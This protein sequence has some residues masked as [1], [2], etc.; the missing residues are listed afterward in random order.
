MVAAVTPISVC[1][2]ARS[3]HRRVVCAQ[4]GNRITCLLLFVSGEAPRCGK[5]LCCGAVRDR[6]PLAFPGLATQQPRSDRA[7]RRRGH[8]KHR[9]ALC[10]C[11]G[12]AGQPRA[13]DRSR[14]ERAWGAGFPAATECANRDRSGAC[15]ARV[16]Q[17][18]SRVRLSLQRSD[19]RRGIAR[20]DLSLRKG[21]CVPTARLAKTLR[22]VR[23]HMVPAAA[24][25]RCTAPCVASVPFSLVCLPGPFAR[26]PSGAC[27]AGMALRD[28]LGSHTPPRCAPLRDRTPARARP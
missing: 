24:C 8:P 4:N 21:G 26:S 19:L 14:I 13:H 25:P 28:R 18:L 9:R 7:P 10:S 11:S 6:Q 20:S 16:A 2:C 1:P 17:Q 22:R 3:R 15:T 5:K 27:A 23:G 12:R